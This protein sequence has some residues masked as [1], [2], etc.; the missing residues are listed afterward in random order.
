[1]ISMVV[2]VALI[3][4]LLTVMEEMMEADWKAKRLRRRIDL[5]RG[6]NERIGM[7]VVALETEYRELVA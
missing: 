1:M 3:L 2:K 7:C 5:L 6:W 4:Y